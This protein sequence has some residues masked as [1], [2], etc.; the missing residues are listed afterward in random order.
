MSFPPSPEKS[1]IKKSLSS[2]REREVVPSNTPGPSPSHG[3]LALAGSTNAV[4]T[5]SSLGESLSSIVD[6]GSYSNPLFSA[7]HGT[8][9]SPASS[10]LR[11]LNLDQRQPDQPGPDQAAHARRHGRPLPGAGAVASRWPCCS[12]WSSSAPCLPSPGRPM[13]S[14]P[15]PPGSRW[16]LAVRTRRAAWPWRLDHHATRASWCSIR[17]E[18]LACGELKAVSSLA[19]CGT[20]CG[21]ESHALVTPGNP[22]ARGCYCRSSRVCYSWSR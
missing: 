15:P 16:T 5:P 11:P 12:P 7:I 13:C 21:S 9:S 6:V 1:P 20:E 3:T 2:G 18:T 8:L 17:S 19:Y 4:V 14:S 22:T 10:T